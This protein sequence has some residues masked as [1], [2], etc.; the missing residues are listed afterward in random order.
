MA[1]DFAAEVDAW[2][3]S[4]EKMADAVLREAV[5]IAAEEAGAHLGD[6]E[7]AEAVRGSLAHQ[8][9]AGGA[10]LSFGS[11]KA[12]ALNYGFTVMDSDGRKHSQPGRNFVGLVARRWPRIVEQ[13]V[14][15]IQK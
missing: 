7:D 15:N 11:E 2:R 8:E 13:A 1:R 3:R 4:A 6:G 14:R 5:R 9:D 10:S 12:K